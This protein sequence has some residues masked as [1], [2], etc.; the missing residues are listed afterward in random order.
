MWIMPTAIKISEDNIFLWEPFFTYVSLCRQFILAQGLD[1]GRQIFELWCFGEP[2]RKI[3]TECL[4]V[5][6]TGFG[7]IQ[8]V[9]LM[10]HVT[11]Y[12]SLKKMESPL[13]RQNS[14][15]WQTKVHSLTSS[16]SLLSSS[17]M[18]SNLSE[19]FI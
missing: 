12:C 8:Q 19:S 11:L 3:K 10:L 18:T 1:T 13:N 15:V 6:Q 16:L 14:C 2:F 4:M 7:D 9:L 17:V 5:L